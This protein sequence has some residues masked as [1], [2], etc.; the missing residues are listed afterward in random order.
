MDGKS[1]GGWLLLVAGAVVF[2]SGRKLGLFA[3]LFHLLPAMD[4]FRVPAR[5][6]FL[7]SLGWSILAG[8]GVDALRARAGDDD[9]WRRLARRSG[10]ATSTIALAALARRFF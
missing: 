8:M 4:R 3:A 5:S 7:A 9:R 1:P 2:A 10:I 6:L